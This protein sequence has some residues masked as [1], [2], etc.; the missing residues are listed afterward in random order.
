MTG[1]LDV[2]GDGVAVAIRDG[3]VVDAGVAS[4]DA[5]ASLDAAGGVVVPGFVDLQCNGAVGIDLTTEPER[6]WEVAAALPRFGVTAWLP[7]IVTSPPDRAERA[8]AALAD[9]PAGMPPLAEPLGLHL[10]GPFLNP[11]R[12]GAHD[13]SLLADPAAEADRAATWSRARGVAVVTLAPELPGALDLARALRAA[14][15]VVAAG[16]TD[17]TYEQLEEAA[18]AGVSMVTHLFNG[19]SPLHHRRPGVPGAALTD[20][21]LR[22]GVI[23][24]GVHVHPAAVALA[25]RLLGERFVLVTDAVAALGTDAAGGQGVRLPDGTLAGADLGMDAAVANLAGFAGTSLADAAA[26]ASAAPAAALGDATRG[27]LR[28]GARGDLVVLGPDGRAR[29]T[30]VGGRVA[31]TT[32]L[33]G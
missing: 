7:T 29:T 33:R 28:T 24:D 14:G 1:S 2:V 18:D 21:R 3:T 31:H 20:G 17:A 32:A 8:L 22:V 11:A 6:M 23:A 19:M 26:A 30:V 12:R 16:H 10:E 15:V 9:R 4:H 27:H 13:P 5:A 25:W